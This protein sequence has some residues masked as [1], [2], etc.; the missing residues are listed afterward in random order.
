MLGLDLCWQPPKLRLWDPSEGVW[1]PDPDDLAA[2][3]A[4]ATEDAAARPATEAELAEEAAARLAA[5]ERASAAEA[6]LDELRARFR[7]TLDT[8]SGL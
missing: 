3:A 5:E 6:E 7:G 1:L 8:P 2:Q 4:R